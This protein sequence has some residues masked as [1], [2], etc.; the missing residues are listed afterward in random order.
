G[1][2]FGFAW[3]KRRTAW[4]TFNL[5]V[6]ASQLLTFSREPGT[7]IDGLYAARAAGT[8]DALTPLP[9]SSQ[10]IAINGRPEWKVNANFTWRHGPWRAGLSG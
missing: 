9:D 4:G 10:L 7:I 6:N 1:M 3:S 5:R 8:I 2:D